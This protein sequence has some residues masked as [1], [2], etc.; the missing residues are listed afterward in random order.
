MQ[1]VAD[2]VVSLYRCTLYLTVVVILVACNVRSHVVEQ[3][4]RHSPHQSRTESG[5]NKMPRAPRASL[6]INKKGARHR[7]L[8]WDCVACDKVTIR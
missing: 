8:G 7:V 1:N 5:H 2:D 3:E 6:L 4:G